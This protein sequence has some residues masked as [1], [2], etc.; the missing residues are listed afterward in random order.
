MTH[1]DCP[2]EFQSLLWLL[3]EPVE[4][5]VAEHFLGCEACSA[6]IRSMRS[7]LEA[8]RE[9]AGSLGALEG[10]CL[11][12]EQVAELVDGGLERAGREPLM[13]HL[14]SCQA[15][16]RAV[17]SVVGALRSSDVAEAIGMLEE[18]SAGRSG[19]STTSPARQRSS[20]TRRIGLT[21]VGLAAAAGLAGLLLLRGPAIDP[22][23]DEPHRAPAPILE[24]VPRPMTPS[25]A[26]NLLD[27]FRWSPVA[28]A[29][30]YRVILFDW[31]GEVLWQVETSQTR[32]T[33]ADTVPLM[34]GRP[35]FWKVEARVG[36]ERW[37]DSG[38]TEFSV[39]GN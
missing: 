2:S 39:A 15:C 18:H 24:S 37:L 30:S 7:T 29:E 23:S 27:E 4:S 36:L 26:V 13:A 16:R 25:G 8:L 14:L 34:S 12:E 17:A 32:I 1:P 6:E 11:D 31:E 33:L 28:A 10:G 38:L 20:R 3:G 5:D 19:P 9:P 35:Y 21:A 22:E